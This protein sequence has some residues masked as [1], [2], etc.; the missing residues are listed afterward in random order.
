M[1]RVSSGY[2]LFRKKYFECRESWWRL[3]RESF[4]PLLRQTHCT[5]RH[6]QNVTQQLDTLLLHAAD[7]SSTWGYVQCDSA[8]LSRA[9]LSFM[10][11]SCGCDHHH[12][13]YHHQHHHHHHHH[14]YRQ[15]LVIL[16]ISTCKFPH[17]I[18]SFNFHIPTLRQGT[19]YRPVDNVYPFWLVM[20][21]VR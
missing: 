1:D 3:Q 15:R 18:H 2:C 21:T 5:F 4:H 7:T 17:G 20:E 14:H 16:D 6:D 9:G 10:L 8:S 12:Y 11:T 13:H 19:A